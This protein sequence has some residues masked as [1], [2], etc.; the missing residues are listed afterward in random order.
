MKE[1]GYSE[2]DIAQAL[3]QGKEDKKSLLLKAVF[4]MNHYNEEEYPMPKMFD[5]WK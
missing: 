3:R 1:E 5:R 2:V 4:R